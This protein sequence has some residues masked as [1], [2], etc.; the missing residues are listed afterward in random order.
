MR[1]IQI[2]HIVSYKEKINNIIETNIPK[3]V[4]VDSKILIEDFAVLSMLNSNG[5]ERN[6]NSCPEG[7]LRKRT[8]S[9]SE[10]NK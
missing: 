9:L 7:F 10:S 4:D 5:N 2:T 6:E 1:M 3:T 8:S